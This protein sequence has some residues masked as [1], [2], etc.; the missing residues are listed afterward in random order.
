[1]QYRK[2]EMNTSFIE[3]SFTLV[4]ILVTYTGKYN[5]IWLNVIMLI[6]WAA[7]INDSMLN[8]PYLFL[9]LLNALTWL[10]CH[11][12]S[13]WCTYERDNVCHSD[14][15]HIFTCTLSWARVWCQWRGSPGRRS[16]RGSSGRRPHTGPRTWTR[17]CRPAGWARV[18][19]GRPRGWPATGCRTRC[20]RPG[21]ARTPS[22]CR[23]HT[24]TASWNSNITLSKSFGVIEIVFSEI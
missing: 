13:A 3:M 9:P 1:M 11:S 15:K 14:Y 2:V 12:E 16:D 23:A 5:Y 17:S 8:S 4:S 19:R 10:K 21:C 20:G 7:G 18:S 22:P 6:Q 24:Q